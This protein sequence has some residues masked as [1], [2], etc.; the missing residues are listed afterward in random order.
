MF[1]Y[2]ADSAAHCTIETSRLRLEPWNDSHFDRFAS[3]AR[4]PATGLSTR[5]TRLE[6]EHVTALHEQSL[7]TW[8]AY[9]FGK[10]A[11][12]EIETGLWLG[13]VELTPGRPNRGSRNEEIE[14]G[15]VV[16]PSRGSE[17]IAVEATLAARDEAFHR[18]QAEQLLGLRRV[19]E[20]ATG[21]VLE[22]A[23]FRP[24][25]LFELEDEIVVE[26]LR[27]ERSDWLEMPEGRVRPTFD[28]YR[29]AGTGGHETR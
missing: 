27:I 25:C 15:C 14:L 26:V 2:Q 7:A 17:G 10:R 11:I 20:T 19:E 13:Y 28:S 6:P 8:K 16:A 22:R 1:V 23:G 29:T 3:M 12:I 18:C 4:D 9:G 21:R 5:R 24:V